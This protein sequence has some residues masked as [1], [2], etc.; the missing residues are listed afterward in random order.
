MVAVVAWRSNLAAA[1]AAAAVGWETA[2]SGCRSWTWLDVVVAV[3][4]DDDAVRC[5]RPMTWTSRRIVAAEI[6]AAAAAAA[7]AGVDDGVLA[8]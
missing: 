6:V 3:A 1:A 8:S 2:S 4:V 5:W 7:A